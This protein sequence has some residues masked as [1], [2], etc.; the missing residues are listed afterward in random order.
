MDCRENVVDISP[1]DDNNAP[2]P[3]HRRW[4]SYSLSPEKARQ[5][6]LTFESAMDLNPLGPSLRSGPQD[7]TSHRNV[8]VNEGVQS[9]RAQNART[10]DAQSRQDG[11][12]DTELAAAK[13]RAQGLSRLTAAEYNHCTFEESNAKEEAA[14]SRARALAALT[15]D[16]T[17]LSCDCVAPEPGS[18]MYYTPRYELE[19]PQDRTQ[20]LMTAAAQSRARALAALTRDDAPL[21]GCDCDTPE[22]GSRKCYTQR[23]K[24]ELPQ[25]RARRFATT[26]GAWEDSG[27]MPEPVPTSS[28]DPQQVQ[29]TTTGAMMEFL[30]GEVGGS[31]LFSNDLATSNIPLQGSGDLDWDFGATAP[32][33][34][35]EMMRDLDDLIAAT[36]APQPQSGHPAVDQ[37]TTATPPIDTSWM[38]TD[39]TLQP[40]SDFP[41]DLVMDDLVMD[42]FNFNDMTYDGVFD[43]SLDDT[44]GVG[45]NL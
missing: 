2:G 42:D 7:L 37:F 11:E 16:D 8:F 6:A 35:A 13:V 30:G 34:D 26:T 25:D 28:V 20:R 19:L 32:M 38:N 9:S 24:L 36:A 17:S 39:E 40:A 44:F 23:H 22:V 3:R 4:C 21:A 1:V 29:N 41:A 10:V 33:N 43:M 27:M 45:S 5:M 31:L 12:W 15:R 14:R 18:R